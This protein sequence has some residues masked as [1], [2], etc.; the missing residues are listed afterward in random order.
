MNSVYLILGGNQGS[1]KENINSTCKM[2]QQNAGKIV[3]TSRLYQ[4]EPWGFKSRELFINQVICIHTRLEPEELL[5]N[6]LRIEQLAGRIRNAAG[7]ASRKMDIDILFFNDLIFNH[8][9]LII[10]HPRLHL[11]KFVLLPMFELAP[12]FI[13]PVFNQTIAQLLDECPDESN[14]VEL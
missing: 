7:Y 4:S 5:D 13:H 3:E 10:P 1:V 11:R 8:E 12:G 6:L 2:I 14:V 9:R